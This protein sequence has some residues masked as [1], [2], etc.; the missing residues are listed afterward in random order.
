MTTAHDSDHLDQYR[1]LLSDAGMAAL[2]RIRELRER[3]ESTLR[4]SERLRGEIDPDLVA[5]ALTQHELRD[6]AAAKFTDADRLFFTR[7]GLEQ[8]TSDVIA[9]HR[10]RR[11][12]GIT[13]VVD[14][15][16]GIGGDLMALAQVDGITHLSGVDLDPVHLLLAGTN[17][18]VVAPGRS[19]DLIC[20]DV[21]E[22]D[23]S[24]YEGV[25][26]DPARRD[27][28]GRLGGITSEP[29]LEWALALART[30]PPVGI[31]TAPGIPHELVPDGWELETIALG[32]D[33]KEAVLWSP[34]L[35]ARTRTASVIS[36]REI[37]QLGSVPGDPVPVREPMPGAW[38]LDPNPS[39]TRAGL[40][41]DLARSIDAAK[42]DEE[43]AFL[44]ADRPVETPFARVLPII[45]AL[46]WHEKRLKARLREL[47]AGPVDIRRRGLPGDVDRLTKRLRGKGSRRLAIAM[48]RVRNAPWAIICDV[49]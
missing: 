41:E 47:D 34:A 11:F 23:L 9:T 2:D 28:R 13:S 15:C 40:V 6:R 16:C 46:P 39:V 17:V 26:I 19:P 8:A 30:I 27:V 18:D 49:E 25:F 29:P 42:V 20:A 21:R 37:H 48:T 3:G 43:I 35:A 31:K 24:P 1:W 44:V 38:L 7:E 14:L 10:A 4:I 36:G 12:A 5:L 22:V 45:D 33:I 32:P